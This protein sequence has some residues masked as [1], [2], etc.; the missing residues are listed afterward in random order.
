MHSHSTLIVIIITKE[1]SNSLTQGLAKCQIAENDFSIVCWKY[2][3][4][5]QQPYTEFSVG[6]IIM[7]V[8]KF[9]VENLEQYVT[10]SYASVI[11]VGDPG[12]V[13]EHSEIP[14][15]VPHSMFNVLVSRDPKECGDST[16]FDAGC[17]QYNPH[18]NSKNVHMKMRVFYSTNMPKFSYLRVN[19]SIK[20]GRTFIVSG[21]IRRITSDF[22]ML[23]VTDIDF[24]IAGAN[25]TL[26]V[27]GSTSSINTD[28]CSDIDMIAE[29]TESAA[30][31]PPKRPRRVTTRSSKQGAGS[32][33][34]SPVIVES[35]AS[36]P[37]LIPST[38]TS[39]ISPN[40]KGKKTLSDLALD[41]TEPIVEDNIQDRRTRVEDAPEDDDDIEFI[42]EQEVEV[43]C[44]KGKIIEQKEVEDNYL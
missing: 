30:P 22:I 31:Q 42:D 43:E 16:Y 34:A 41:L 29:D 8:G 39:I 28:R 15:S 23:E 2:F 4:P 33:S 32:S 7:F 25:T 38:K 17:Y 37:N 44:K 14:L 24:M 27:Q 11:A 20:I 10:V 1:D 21:F 19:N 35:A 6:D 3:Y 12:Q 18:T 5:F 36:L 13:F 26:N 9:V 40:R